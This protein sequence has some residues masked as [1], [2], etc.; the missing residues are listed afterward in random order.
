MSLGLSVFALGYYGLDGF[1]F[2][3]FQ[4]LKVLGSQGLRVLGFEGFGVW[5]CWGVRN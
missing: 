4:G 5:E 2:L 1:W 3:G